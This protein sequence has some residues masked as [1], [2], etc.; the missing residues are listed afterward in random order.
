MKLNALAEILEAKVLFGKDSRR[1]DIDIS[2]VVA[3]D[4]MSDV[5]ASA[6]VPD[7][8]LTRLNNLQ[9]IRTSSVFG[10]K[11]VI[12]VENKKVQNNLIELAEEENII[13]LS[14]VMSMFES[15]GKL[16]ENGLRSISH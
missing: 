4:L 9:V 5:L 8:L 12:I 3:S 2:S 1:M 16:Y 15:C 10:I 14:T 13:L 7:L 11:V 6:E